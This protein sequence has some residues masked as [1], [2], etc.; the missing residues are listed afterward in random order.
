MPAYCAEI[1]YSTNYKKKINENIEKFS[2]LFKLK[3]LLIQL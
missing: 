2:Y 1:T 3:Y